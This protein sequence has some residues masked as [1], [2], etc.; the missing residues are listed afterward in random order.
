MPVGPS[1]TA[2]SAAEL[3]TIEKKTSDASATLRGESANF[4][5]R[6]INRSGF[7]LWRLYPVT[8][9]HLASSR[10]TISLPITPKPTNPSFA[11]CPGLLISNKAP[12]PGGRRHRE[13]CQNLHAPAEDAPSW[14]SGRP[15]DR[16][17]RLLP[18][19][20]CDDTALARAR[21]RR[22]KSRSS[23]PAAAPRWSQSRTGSGD[24]PPPPPAPSE[25]PDRLR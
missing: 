23:A 14:P 7:P 10:T 1:I 3:V 21:L 19:C 13:H 18:G 22:G 9:C 2:P 8:V 24:S 11:T 12:K 20:A 16:D 4:I 17:V 15:P 5:P 6:S 25:N